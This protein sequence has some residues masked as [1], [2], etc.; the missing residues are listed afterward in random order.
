MAIEADFT[1]GPPLQG[2]NIRLIETRLS[3]EKTTLEINLIE[4]W[5]GSVKFEALS[6]VWGKQAMMQRI[7]Y[8]G[9]PIYIG[10]SLV[11]ALG[12]LARR[13]STGLLWAD[14]ICIKQNDIQEKTRQVRM[15]RDIY[16]KAQR[17]IIWLGKEQASD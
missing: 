9:R 11:D 13:R 2:C 12:E 3:S 10:S 1:Y 4:R 14:A 17:V 8:N 5:P 16:E 15:M 6:Y 7:K